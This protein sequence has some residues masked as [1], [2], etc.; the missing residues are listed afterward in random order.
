M[1]V[2]IPHSEVS[3]IGPLLLTASSMATILSL[4]LQ[5]VVIGTI[6]T[7]ML[8]EDQAPGNR[9]RLTDYIIIA[10]FVY[11]LESQEMTMSIPELASAFMSQILTD[12]GIS[13]S[14]QIMTITDYN[15]SNGFMEPTAIPRCM[16]SENCWNLQEGDGYCTLDTDCE[17]HLKCGKSCMDFAEIGISGYYKKGGWADHGHCCYDEL[18]FTSESDEAESSISMYIIIAGGALILFLTLAVVYICR[19][20][21]K[22]SVIGEPNDKMRLEGWFTRDNVLANDSRDGSPRIQSCSQIISEI[23]SSDLSE[24][25]EG[26]NKPKGNYLLCDP[27]PIPHKTTDCGEQG[28]IAERPIFAETE[29]HDSKGSSHIEVSLDHDVTFTGRS[30]PRKV[31]MSS[32]PNSRTVNDDDIM[33]E[34]MKNKPIMQQVNL[35]DTEQSIEEVNE[36]KFGDTY[37]VSP[38]NDYL[39]TLGE[40]SL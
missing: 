17:Q 27:I 13:Y 19:R 14:V 25:E 23:I 7:D 9:R 22:L 21:S 18:M 24:Q 26:G 1:L 40:E 35:S 28:E 32:I 20:R 30:F 4:D 29:G 37:I 12:I 36:A 38:G 10:Y 6:Y 33:D 34:D 11:F 15:V 8:S 2:N 31:A 39:I 16:G 5:Q 3:S